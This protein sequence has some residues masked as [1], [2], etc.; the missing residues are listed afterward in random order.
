MLLARRS[1]ELLEGGK[2]GI[3]GGFLEQ[4]ETCIDGA[5]R[6]VYYGTI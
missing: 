6:E 4:D 2:W 1:P 5:R 3:L